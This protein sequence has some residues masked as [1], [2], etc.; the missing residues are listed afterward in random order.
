MKALLKKGLC[1]TINSDDPSYF[2][3]YL[4]KNFL[5]TQKALGLTRRDIAQLCA[6][7]FEASFLPAE[8][9][10]AYLKQISEIAGLSG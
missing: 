5:E 9:K 6:N 4:E 7:S 3:G 10:A 8:T 1:V 2:G